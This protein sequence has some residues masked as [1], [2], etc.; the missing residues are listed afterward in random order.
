M[1]STRMNIDPFWE[2]QVSLAKGVARL[3]RPSLAKLHH[4]VLEEMG[5]PPGLDLVDFFVELAGIPEEEVREYFRFIG[6]YAAAKV[7]TEKNRETEVRRLAGQVAR[8][9]DASVLKFRQAYA[10][11]FNSP[12]SEQHVGYFLKEVSRQSHDPS[13]EWKG[14]VGGHAVARR[15]ATMPGATVLSFREAYHQ[16][17]GGTPS[18]ELTQFF[19]E[20]L[21]HG[22]EK[23]EKEDEDDDEGLASQIEFAR[24][25]AGTTATTIL[26]FRQ[27]F[28]K[29]YGSAPSA[30]VTEAFLQQL[31]REKE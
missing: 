21:R 12:P 18:A 31:S 17:I 6:E 7:Q 19:L 16:E 22:G 3:P 26:Q 9:P 2:I 24:T 29:V 14:Q 23:V 4:E 30:E 10:E 28:E 20:Q 15:I 13:A 11:Q 1:S 27:A 5:K 25:V 8:E